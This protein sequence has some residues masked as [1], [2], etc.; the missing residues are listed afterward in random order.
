MHA[1]LTETGAYGDISS[2]RF[3]AIPA[4]SATAGGTENL[5]H[6]VSIDQVLQ[7]PRHMLRVG[8]EH[9]GAHADIGRHEMH[10]FALVAVLVVQA[11]DQVE[12]GSHQPARA[13]LG[14][15]TVLMMYSVE[16]T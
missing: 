16:P 4:F 1:S 13:R 8:A 3:S 9:G 11:I 10:I 6:H 14:S 2:M 7:H 12:F 15:A 5:V